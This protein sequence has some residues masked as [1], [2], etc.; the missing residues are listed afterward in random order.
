MLGG[1]D[2]RWVSSPIRVWNGTCDRRHKLSLVSPAPPPPVH[3]SH[4]EG[5]QSKAGPHKGKSGHKA[6][7]SWWAPWGRPG[8]Y[9]HPLPLPPPSPAYPTLAFAPSFLPGCIE[10]LE[11]PNRLGTTLFPLPHSHFHPLRISTPEQK[12]RGGT[13]CPS[14]ESSGVKESS[15]LL[16]TDPHEGKNLGPGRSYP[17]SSDKT[18]ARPE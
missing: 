16:L 14:L 13:Y 6:P 2:P 18:L 8:P 1:W 7:S 11:L 10:I 3:R 5:L 4:E 17:S 9:I 12:G 15:Q